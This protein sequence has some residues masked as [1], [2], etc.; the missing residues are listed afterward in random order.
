MSTPNPRR[1]LS[2][3]QFIV[4]SQDRILLEVGEVELDT[5]RRNILI[6]CPYLAP[7]LRPPPSEVRNPPT[8]QAEAN[9]NRHAVPENIYNPPIRDEPDMNANNMPTNN[10]SRP[11]ARFWIPRYNNAQQFPQPP[12]QAS[13][14]GLENAYNNRPTFPFATPAAYPAEQGQDYESE[15]D[16]N[17]SDDEDT[18]LGSEPPGRS[19]PPSTPDSS[20]PDSGASP[21]M[22]LDMDSDTYQQALRHIRHGVF[23]HLTLPD[24]SLDFVGYQMLE[25]QAQ[26]LGMPVLAWGCERLLRDFQVLDGDKRTLC[27]F[28]EVMFRWYKA[29]YDGKWEEVRR[30]QGQGQGQGA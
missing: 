2:L 20:T 30:W 29:H 11:T 23:P 15:E 5:S 21:A 12:D 3:S 26:M 27:G 7:Y 17:A 8:D 28:F 10:R 22:F 25:Q 14:S 4:P 19:D 9:F 1:G 13:R 24:G 18:S 16:G 6:M